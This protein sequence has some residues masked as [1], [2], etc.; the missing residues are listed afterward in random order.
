M[1]AMNHCVVGI[2]RVSIKHL[3]RLFGKYREPLRFE[4]YETF[5]A[6]FYT[7]VLVHRDFSVYPRSFHSRLTLF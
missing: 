2:K 7:F 1:R 4:K 3:S 5:K 6:V